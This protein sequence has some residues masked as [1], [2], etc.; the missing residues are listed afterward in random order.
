MPHATRGGEPTRT[1]LVSRRQAI[2]FL[3]AFRLRLFQEASIATTAKNPFLILI[4]SSSFLL[5]AN[6]SGGVFRRSNFA[7][8]A[9]VAFRVWRNHAFEELH[10]I[11]R[12][13]EK[14]IVHFR[15]VTVRIAVLQCGDGRVPKFEI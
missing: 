9:V 11:K 4:P 6:F 8:L 12:T 2:H 15:V 1:R 7:A 14:P 13:V 10:D 5:A 3:A